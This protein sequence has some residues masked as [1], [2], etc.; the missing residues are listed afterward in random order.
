MSNV[1]PGML[2]YPI[3]S[4][5]VALWLPAAAEAVCRPLPKELRGEI[6]VGVWRPGTEREWMNVG[7]IRFSVDAIRLGGERYRLCFVE[8]LPSRGDVNLLRQNISS[9]SDVLVFSVEATKKGQRPYLNSKY[10]GISQFSV[11]P[12]IGIK[13]NWVE[14]FWCQKL[15]DLRGDRSCSVNDYVCES[16]ACL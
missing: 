9:P 5:V 4:L 12:A 11:G 2:N 1:R 3:L 14:T 16:G 13:Q 15:E 7:L 8:R 6:P 10:L